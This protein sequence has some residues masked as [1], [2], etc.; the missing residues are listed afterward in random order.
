MT[1]EAA[2]E[3]SIGLSAEERTELA[4]L[5]NELRTDKQLGSAMAL[6]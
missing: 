5:I 1:E 3:I 2:T 6:P 4:E